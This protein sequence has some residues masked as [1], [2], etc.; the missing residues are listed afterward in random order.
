MQSP[1]LPINHC[2]TPTRTRELIQHIFSSI[3]GW[4]IVENETLVKV[5]YAIG[6]H[7]KNEKKKC[8]VIYVE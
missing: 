2:T 6:Y 7:K 5:G 4:G 3:E 1:I 8:E